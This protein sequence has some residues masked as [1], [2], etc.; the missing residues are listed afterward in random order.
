ML[1]D[2]RIAL[3]A[4]N[5]GF[6]RRL[7]S[8]PPGLALGLPEAL[9]APQ[10]WS[11]TAA[12]AACLGLPRDLQRLCHA[13]KLRVEKDAAGHRL[14]MRVARPR[15]LD[16]LTWWDGPEDMQRMAE[17]CAADVIAEAHIDQT[18]PELSPVEREVWLLTEL[19]NDRGILVD[20]DPARTTA[21]I[22]RDRQSLD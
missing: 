11:D 2:E 5:A 6:E 1:A 8:G 7:L 18:L 13:L 12:R 20:R 14:M 3:T 15:R 19:M 17:Y 4:H 9:S 10:R 22:N 21:R 16:P